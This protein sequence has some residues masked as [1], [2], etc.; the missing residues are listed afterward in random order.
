MLTNVLQRAPISELQRAR[1]AEF[2]RRPSLHTQIIALRDYVLNNRRAFVDL[3][4]TSREYDS[5][6]YRARVAVEFAATLRQVYAHSSIPV[7]FT[8]ETRS[9]FDAYGHTLS[10]VR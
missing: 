5:L 6:P 1:D 9:L 7:T 2:A 8:R 4:L 10:L 3:G